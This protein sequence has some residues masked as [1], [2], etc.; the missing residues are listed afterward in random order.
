M[1]SKNHSPQF[2]RAEVSRMADLDERM[3]RYYENKSIIKPSKN[4][5]YGKTGVTYSYNDC[6]AAIAISNLRK[7]GMNL[8]DIKS[9][10][11]NAKNSKEI[12]EKQIELLEEKKIEIEY[13]EYRLKLMY[14]Y[15]K[16]NKFLKSK[17]HLKNIYTL[18]SKNEWIPNNLWPNLDQDDPYTVEVLSSFLELVDACVNPDNKKRYSEDE[19]RKIINELYSLIEKC[20]PYANRKSSF[21]K[22]EMKLTMLL[23]IDDYYDGEIIPEEVE[24]DL[25]ELLNL[26]ESLI[27]DSIE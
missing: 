21:A 22:L 18:I 5:E 2:T 3:L 17:E 6:V 1:K 7:L 25:T 15:E 12:Y 23:Y 19:G 27:D 4:Y 13:Q 8:Y 20:I 16:Y 14:I 10:L 9:L 11:S 26:F 24:Q